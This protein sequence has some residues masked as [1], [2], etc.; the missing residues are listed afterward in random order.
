MIPLNSSHTFLMNSVT[1]LSLVIY[2]S[3]NI[4]AIDESIR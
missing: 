3:N 1:K 4:Q 2:R